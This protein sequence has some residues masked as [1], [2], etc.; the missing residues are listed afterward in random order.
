M[1]ID[2]SRRKSEVASE[3][4]EDLDEMTLYQLAE[5]Y[6]RMMPQARPLTLLA[7][8]DHHPCSACSWRKADWMSGVVGAR[9]KHYC[10][11]CVAHIVM[12]MVVK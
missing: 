11:A 1:S 7:E 10:R 8:S 6:A 2:W 5:E 12:G 9:P 3:P 4:T